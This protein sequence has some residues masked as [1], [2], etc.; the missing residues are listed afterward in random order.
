MY[1]FTME[2]FS[3]KLIIFIECTCVKKNLKLI[4]L[5]KN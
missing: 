3:A 5:F 4:G 2:E 1:N